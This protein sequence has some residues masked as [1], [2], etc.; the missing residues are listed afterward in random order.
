MV[1]WFQPLSCVCGDCMFSL[2]FRELPLG[3]LVFSLSPKTC[4]LICLCKKSSKQF[5]SGPPEEVFAWLLTTS[6]SFC[7]SRIHTFT[8]ALHAIITWNIARL[9]LLVY[10]PAYFEFE[11]SVVC[12]VTVCSVCDCALWGVGTTSRVSPAFWPESRGTDCRFPVTLV[13]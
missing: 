9:S 12:L 6:G 10:E 13:G 7:T 2:G 11:H 3:T 8:H 5:L 4:S 1:V